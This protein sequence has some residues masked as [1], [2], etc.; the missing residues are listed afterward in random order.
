M[1]KMAKWKFY[2]KKETKF[3]LKLSEQHFLLVE[4][5][6]GFLFSQKKINLRLRKKDTSYPKKDT[7]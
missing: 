6:D 3:G 5:A 4:Q 2:M 7:I 1:D